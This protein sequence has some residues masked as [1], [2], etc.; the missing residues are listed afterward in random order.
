MYM[1]VYQ[2]GKL[3]RGINLVGAGNPVYGHD[4]W[5]RRKSENQI[6]QLI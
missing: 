5:L 6:L 3:L 1:Y 2:V 4:N